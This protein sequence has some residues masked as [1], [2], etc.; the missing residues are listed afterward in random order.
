MEKL[1]FLT[2]VVV[3]GAA[4]MSH[5]HRKAGFSLMEVNMAVFVMAVGIMSLVGLFPLGLRESYQGKAD[6]QQ[7]MF[8]DY[9]LNQLVAAL[10]QTNLYWSEWLRMDG[11]A[12][13]DSVKQGKRT[14]AKT[15]LPSHTDFDFEDKLDLPGAW[16]VA[17]KGMQPK[18]YRIF[19]DI[20]RMDTD[21]K[22]LSV[23]KPSD[24]VMGIAVRST[25]ID[26][27]AYENYTNNVLYYAE[28]MFQGDATK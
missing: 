9:A 19:F 12:Y 7:A 17:G 14:W 13:P 20:L 2:R 15:P 26:A 6:L 4:A 11:T 21:T 24:R 27:P 5:T 25:D 8:A 3:K 18:H 22:P 1:R 23:E 10:S 16:T 28:V